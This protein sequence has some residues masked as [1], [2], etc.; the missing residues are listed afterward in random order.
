MNVEL[1]NKVVEFHE[2][3]PERFSMETWYEPLSPGEVTSETLAPVPACGTIGCIAGTVGIITGSAN[4][5]EDEEI[6]GVIRYEEPDS[7]W[8]EDARRQLKL[9]LHQARRL[10]YTNENMTSYPGEH[11]PGEDFTAYIAAKTQAERVAALKVRVA[12]FIAT[13]GQE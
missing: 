13:N 9:D 7:G 12:K 5:Y 1:L 4:P 11:W 2:E 8:F 10:F 6:E 3:M